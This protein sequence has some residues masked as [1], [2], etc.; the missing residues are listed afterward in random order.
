LR[1]PGGNWTLQPPSIDIT[2]GESLWLTSAIINPD[3]T[4]SE[5]W[6]FPVRISGEQGPK[7]DTGPAGP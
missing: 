1:N 6:S 3:D 2:E 5:N 4:L 7:G